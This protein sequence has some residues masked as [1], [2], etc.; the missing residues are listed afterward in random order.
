MK[1][2]QK[3]DTITVHHLICDEDNIHT[4]SYPGVVRF[5]RKTGQAR[6][7]YRFME[8]MDHNISYGSGEGE[9]AAACFAYPVKRICQD[10]NAIFLAGIHPNSPYILPVDFMYLSGSDIVCMQRH[11]A[12]ST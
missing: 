2:K 11:R 5:C 12:A 3:D 8:I 10:T 4:W 6:I 1:Q 9:G 7:I